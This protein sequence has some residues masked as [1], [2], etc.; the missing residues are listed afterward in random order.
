MSEYI[1]IR[2]HVLSLLA[3]HMQEIRTRFGI[4]TL[5]LFGSVSRGEDTPLS[6]ID[7]L[8]T[9]QPGALSLEHVA[10]LEDYLENL[11]ERKVDLVS[12][13]WINPYFRDT[14]LREAI[15]V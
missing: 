2:E 13:K 4:D 1:S 14:V 3:E 11:F 6:D 9:F 5:Q 12:R 15:S 7:L 8:Y 10:G